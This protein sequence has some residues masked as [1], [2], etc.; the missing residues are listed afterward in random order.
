MMRKGFPEEVADDFESGEKLMEMNR[1]T[2]KAN[3][4]RD[5]TLNQGMEVRQPGLPQKPQIGDFFGGPVVKNS[6]CKAGDEGSVPGQ[7]T[8]IPRAA[9]KLSLHAEIIGPVLWS[10][11]AATMT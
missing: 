3:P 8:K 5:I 4:G 6:S 11:Q 9:G 7:R 1:N 10:L 2:Q